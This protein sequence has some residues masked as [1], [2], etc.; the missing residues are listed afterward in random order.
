M[1]RRQ[2]QRQALVTAGIE[3]QEDREQSH[4]QQQHGATGGA[5]GEPQ[6]L[7]AN[8]LQLV[9]GDELGELTAEP[10]QHADASEQFGE[11]RDQGRHQLGQLV[12]LR[13]QV[14]QQQ[15]CELPAQQA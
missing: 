5:A 7:G 6:Q 13:Q 10:L 2:R 15:F 11:P 1:G 8:G 4:Q 14:R 12:E 3:H 9:D